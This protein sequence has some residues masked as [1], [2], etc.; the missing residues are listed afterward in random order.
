MAGSDI[1]AV[2]C[3]VPT[4]ARELVRPDHFEYA[5]AFAVKLPPGNRMAADDWARAVFTPR[6]SGQQALASAWNAVMGLRPPHNGTILGPF[7]VVPATQESAILVGDGDRYR[8]HLVV[9][10]GG[11]SLTL[12]TFVQSR[13]RAWRELLRGILVGHR[14]VAPRII[15]R[16]VAAKTR[17]RRNVEMQT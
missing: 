12:A 17:N 15:E 7:Q 13:G 5:D 4:R 3:A 9:M 1:H 8:I 10:T 16:A 14:L 6:G 2:A 11:G